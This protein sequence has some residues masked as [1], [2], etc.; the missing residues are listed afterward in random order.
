MGFIHEDG[1]FA[2]LI[3]IVSSDLR[4]STSLVE[5]DYWV[6]HVLWSLAE[7]DF[8]VWFKG[9]TSLSKG[10]GLIQRFS[11][12]LDLK[13]EHPD[14]S[15][16]GNW[17]SEGKTA[18]ANRKVFFDGLINLLCIPG[19]DTTELTEQRA[20]ADRGIV[21]AAHHPIVFDDMPVGMRPFVRLHDA[22][23]WVRS[24]AG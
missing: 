5:K 10:F 6:T 19:M 15:P 23:E 20:N 13:L 17:K 12:D 18:T 2:D 21:V 3:Q 14:L 7:Q 1:G 22:M 9:G 4:I 24:S 8:E 16:I 11:E